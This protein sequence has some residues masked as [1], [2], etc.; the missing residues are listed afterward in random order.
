MRK[1]LSRS[2]FSWVLLV[3]LGLGAEVSFAAC[4]NVTTGTV[5]ASFQGTECLTDIPSMRLK[6]RSL[7]GRYAYFDSDEVLTGTVVEASYRGQYIAQKN[8]QVVGSPFTGFLTSDARVSLDGRA[9]ASEY[10]SGIEDLGAEGRLEMNSQ[11]VRDGSRVTLYKDGQQLGPTFQGWVSSLSETD[12]TVGL[13]RAEEHRSGI[14][15]R[16]EERRVGEECRSRWS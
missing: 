4:Q 14:E 3:S 2:V 12:A 13:N 15:D 6:A 7:N 5:E 8:G 10:R 1:R 16:S 11:L 9:R